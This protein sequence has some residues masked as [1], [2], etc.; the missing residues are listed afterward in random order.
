MP[1]QTVNDH[2][3]LQIHTVSTL[4][5]V[6]HFHILTPRREPLGDPPDEYLFPRAE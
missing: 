3:I 6:E 1:F 4:I 5:H 2:R